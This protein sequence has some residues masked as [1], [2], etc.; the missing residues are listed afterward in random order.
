MRPVTPQPHTP[1]L[2]YYK[3]QEILIR[4]AEQKTLPYVKAPHLLFLDK[5]NI[6]IAYKRGTR[7]NTEPAADW[8][9]FRYNPTT[10]IIS[11]RKIVAHL[12]GFTIQNRRICPIRQWRYWPVRRSAF[13]KFQRQ[14]RATR[15]PIFR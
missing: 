11:D 12:D 15:I 9:M 4:A 14:I 13:P 10:G 8:E 7:H 6:L 2:P 1:I 5:H 3:T